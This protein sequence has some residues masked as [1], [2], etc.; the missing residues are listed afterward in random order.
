MSYDPVIIGQFKELE[1][2]YNLENYI[3]IYAYDLRFNEKK[4]IEK[5]RHYARKKDLKI[6]SV[7]YYQTWCDKNIYPEPK[8]IF[9]WFLK[10]QYI[11][12]DTFHGTIFSM[13]S[14]K[15]F[16]TIVRD[17]NSNKLEDL[18]KKCGMQDR[19]VSNAENLVYVMEKEID[20]SKFEQL[21]KFAKEKTD[22]YLEKCINGGK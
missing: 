22:L 4:Y 20:Y 15:K 1:C 6:Y 10:A 8:D 5:I 9:E 12:T 2:K 11:I 16:V 21:R 17:S 14:H 18:I 19:I 7:G 3:L 13:R